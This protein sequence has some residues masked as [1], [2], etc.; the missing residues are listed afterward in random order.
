MDSNYDKGYN[1]VGITTTIA[2]A[3]SAYN[4]A[5]EFSRCGVP[6]IMGGFHASLLPEECLEHCDA[7]VIGEV[8]YS[9]PELLEGFRAGRMKRRYKADRFHDLKNLPLPRWELL[10]RKKYFAPFVP[11]MTTRG[12]PFNFS[13]CEVPV[14]YGTKYRHRPIGEVNE[15]F[16]RIPSKNIQI[17]DAKIAG[18]HEY[19]REL[20]KAMMPLKVR[21]SCLWTINTSRD[22]E[23]LDL[24]LKAGVYHVNMASNRFRSRASAPSDKNKTRYPSTPIC[25]RPW[26]SGGYSTLSISSSASTRTPE[27]YSMRPWTFSGK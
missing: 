21:W 24:A 4:I 9:W 11:L 26:R 5:A 12:C 19:S 20:F 8:E 25:C 6:V 22:E 16:R 18:N 1:L 10:D 7:V 23:L 17:V 15:D 13:F 14:V 27:R 2:T 3:A